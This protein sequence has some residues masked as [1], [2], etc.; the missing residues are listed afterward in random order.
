MHEN[1]E[2][3]VEDPFV[4][5]SAWNRALVW[6]TLALVAW[7]GF[8]LTAQ[9][10]VVAAVVCSK[11]GWNDLLTALWLRRRDPHRGRGRA[12]SWF[13]LSA[14]VTKMVIAAFTLT[15]VISAVLISIEGVKPQANP[16]APFPVVV[17]GPGILMAVGLPILALL[18]FVGCVSARRHHV[19]VWI[20][21]PLHR[22]RR[23]AAW[24]PDFSGARMHN[25][26]RGPWLLMVA[27]VVV[28]AMLLATLVGAFTK[29]YVLGTLALIGPIF[30]IGLL[31]RGTF[32]AS[33]GECWDEA[34]AE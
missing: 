29:S 18:A 9:P 31:S 28:A 3:T 16:N 2:T 5:Q 25:M 20:D 1:S 23:A 33:P 11:F 4:P 21:E 15:M 7:L 27:F 14:G 30:G 17:W 22:A 6:S 13:C 19:R 26:A 24:P 8:E 32:A 12:C 34:T 10:A